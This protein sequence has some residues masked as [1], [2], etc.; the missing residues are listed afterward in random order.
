M[1]AIIELPRLSFLTLFSL[2]FPTRIQPQTGAHEQDHAVYRHWRI[3]Q[4]EIQITISYRRDGRVQSIR[5][6][7]AVI[8]ALLTPPTPKYVTLTT[9]AKGCN[10]AAAKSKQ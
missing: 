2:C 3:D 8:S 10:A 5:R 9:H 7:I 1:T 6:R 4:G